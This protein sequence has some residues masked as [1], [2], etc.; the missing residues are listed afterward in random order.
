MDEM[1][2]HYLKL[3]RDLYRGGGTI[4][5]REQ[6]LPYVSFCIDDAMSE[7]AIEDMPANARLVG[8]QCGFEPLF[9]AIWSYLDVRID[10]AEA[11]ELAACYLLERKWFAAG[12]ARPA[13]YIL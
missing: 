9:V 11:E 10:D 13:D 5:Q 4:E 7:R 2:S 12:E 8:W 3:A 6:A 1:K